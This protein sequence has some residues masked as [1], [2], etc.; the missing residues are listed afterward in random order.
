MASPAARPSVS[1]RRLIL[2]AASRLFAERGYDATTINDIGDAVGISGPGLYRHFP[3]KRAVLEALLGE[4]VAEF[5]QRAAEIVESA[6]SP[7]DLVEKLVAMNVGVILDNREL[8]AACWVEWSTS[9][10]EDDPAFSGPV[11]QYLDIWRSALARVRPDLSDQE[12]VVLAQAVFWLM[13][14]TCFYDTSV[15]RPQLQEL[16]TRMTVG[17]IVADADSTPRRRPTRLGRTRTR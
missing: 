12:L 13:R 9:A 14:S 3:S 17:A 15:P 8:N 16:V 11:H 6:P 4:T 2:D 10:V 7:L 1:R 5:A